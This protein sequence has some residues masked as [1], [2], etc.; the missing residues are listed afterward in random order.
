MPICLKVYNWLLLHSKSKK[1]LAIKIICFI[2]VNILKKCSV[3]NSK[4]DVKISVS[5]IKKMKNIFHCFV[6]F[7]FGKYLQTKNLN[8]F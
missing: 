1:F 5:K 3:T 6:C 7:F 2:R 4:K 8:Y